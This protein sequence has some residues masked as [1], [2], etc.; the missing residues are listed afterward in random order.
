MGSYKNTNTLT[1]GQYTFG[2]DEL[3]SLIVLYAYTATST[4]GSNPRKAFQ[5]GAYQAT[6][7]SLSILAGLCYSDNATTAGH[8]LAYSNNDAGFNVGAGSF[9]S[10]VYIDG[11]AQALKQQTGNAASIDGYCY[12]GTT[13]PV[14]KY[15]AVFTIGN[16][17]TSILYC[18]QN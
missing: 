17:I 7:G 15:P 2:P 10:L 13:V 3:A 5:S 11:V 12:L 16:A 8:K 4:N 9:T 1:I 18:K 6:G 14:N